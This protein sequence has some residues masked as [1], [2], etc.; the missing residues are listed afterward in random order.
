MRKREV[1][2]Q[3]G[4]VDEAFKS[5]AKVIEAEYEWP[6]Q[7][8]ASMDPACALVEIKDGN[9]TCWSGTQKSHFVQQGLAAILQMPLD[10]VRVIWTMGPAPTAATT[11]TTAPMDAAVLAQGG[12]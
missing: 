10:K 9:V 2:K 6:F 7:S 11:P 4:D 12:R 1:E 5:A 8:H 3:N